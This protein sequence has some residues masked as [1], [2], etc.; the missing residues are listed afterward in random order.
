MVSGILPSFKQIIIIILTGHYTHLKYNSTRAVISIRLGWLK[1]GAPPG[2]GPQNFFF[3]NYIY[4]Y[5]YL[6]VFV[7]FN[8]FYYYYYLA[9]AVTSTQN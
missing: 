8:F 2:Q 7:F 5:I 1:S 6:F 3:L 4:I 9:E